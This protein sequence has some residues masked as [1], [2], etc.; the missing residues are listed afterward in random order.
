M[1][2]RGPPGCRK[3][4]HLAFYPR[5]V[6]HGNGKI[7]RGHRRS[8]TTAPLRPRKTCDSRGDDEGESNAAAQ[9]G[10]RYVG[11]RAGPIG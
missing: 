11:A 4:N 7:G 5:Q 8:F 10:G 1:L 9:S 3:T 2:L 6:V